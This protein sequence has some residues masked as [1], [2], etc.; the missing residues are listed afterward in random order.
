[1]ENVS[2]NPEPTEVVFHFNVADPLHYAARLL[3]KV[4]R[5]GQ[6]VTLW[7][8]AGD[9]EPISQWLWTHDP[10]AFVPHAKVGDSLSVVERSP[11][12]ITDQYPG[13]RGGTVV[14]ITSRLAERVQVFR[15]FI[16]IVGQEEAA[17]L[18]ARARWRHYQ[19]EGIKPSGFDSSAR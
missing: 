17:R 10:L 12:F 11:V 1:M 6:S 5:L 9:V 3:R 18:D 15:K 7:C 16:D 2:V 13:D 14:N 8:H 19:G 4:Y